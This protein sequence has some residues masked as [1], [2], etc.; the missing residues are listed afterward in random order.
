MICLDIV[1]ADAFD[2]TNGKPDPETSKSET[3]APKKST[4]PATTEEREETKGE[5]INKDGEA[6]DT[7]I[8]AIKNGLKKLRAKND[9]YEGYVTECVKK[10]KAGLTKTEAEDLLIEIGNKVAE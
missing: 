9:S 4:K 6:T 1:E 5:L 10:I 2:A 3:K 8:K 7:Q